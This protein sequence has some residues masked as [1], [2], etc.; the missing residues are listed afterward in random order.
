MVQNFTKEE[1]AIILRALVFYF[2]EHEDMKDSE[3]AKNTT[4]LIDYIFNIK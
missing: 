4:E 2:K 1:L 3:I